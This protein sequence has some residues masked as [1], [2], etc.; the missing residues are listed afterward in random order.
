VAFLR[1]LN[2]NTAY[3]LYLRT[4][5]GPIGCRL[6]GSDWRSR[7]QDRSEGLI[8]GYTYGGGGALF[9]SPQT[10]LTRWTRHRVFSGSTLI[11]SEQR[12]DNLVEIYD[13]YTSAVVSLPLNGVFTGVAS[14]TFNSIGPKTWV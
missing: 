13:S 6:P 14:Q 11:S 7:A 1:Y 8:V 10:Q 2:V 3:V 5:L 12:Q 9:S 4:G